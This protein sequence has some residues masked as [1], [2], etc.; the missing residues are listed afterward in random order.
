MSRLNLRIKGKSLKTEK[1]RHVPKKY[2][3]L[4]NTSTKVNFISC[5][6][7]I[8]YVILNTYL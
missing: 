3:E 8:E 7:V 6:F 4:I 2:G 1:L 5:L